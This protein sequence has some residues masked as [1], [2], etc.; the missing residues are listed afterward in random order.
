MNREQRRHSKKNIKLSDKHGLNPSINVCPFCGKD[1]E[2]LLFGR[3][4]GDAKAPQRVISNY[5]PCD[6]CKAK[7]QHGVTVIE[8][9]TE[10]RD[11]EPITCNPVPAWMTGRWF[12]I[13][14]RLAIALFGVQP[15]NNIVLLEK[16]AYSKLR[17]DG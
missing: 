2:I 3:L 1:K 15:E 10:Y 14:V 8:V 9:T 7:M 17:G 16:E 13:A 4:K 12:V 5:E 6:E 11:M